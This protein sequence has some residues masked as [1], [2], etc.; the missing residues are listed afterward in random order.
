MSETITLKPCE[1][2]LGLPINK[3]ILIKTA[4]GNYHIG[5][6]D[7]K[8]FSTGINSCLSTITVITHYA[9]LEQ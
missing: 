8:I 9:I 3:R 5:E 6:F 4:R 7:G 1:N 2:Q